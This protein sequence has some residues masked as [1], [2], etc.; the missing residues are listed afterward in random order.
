MTGNTGPHF[1][2]FHPAGRQR[3]KFGTRRRIKGEGEAGVNGVKCVALPLWERQ[4]RSAGR[5]PSAGICALAM[6]LAVGLMLATGSARAG[7]DSLVSGP[8]AL[9]SLVIM[10][11]TME[12]ATSRRASAPGKRVAQNPGQ[13]A[14]ERAAAQPVV[15]D[16]PLAQFS[17]CR[18]PATGFG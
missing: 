4:G 5:G 6:A 18:R 12:D 11:K 17:G 14:P 10:V 13:E 2:G 15:E 7:N 9:L 1:T 8:A 16:E 3:E